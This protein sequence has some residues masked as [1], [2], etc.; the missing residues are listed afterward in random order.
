MKS[1]KK[2]KKKGKL[3]VFSS[4]RT[5]SSTPSS[6]KM[7]LTSLITSSITDLYNL[8]MVF[9][10]AEFAISTDNTNKKGGA[11]RGNKMKTKRKRGK[12]KRTL[13]GDPSHR[14]TEGKIFQT[15]S[16]PDGGEGSGERRKGRTEGGGV[17]PELKKKLEN[18]P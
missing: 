3:T 9:V 10:F 11:P 17:L 7:S 6:K 13:E 4:I 14:K 2:E 18:H 12:K 5:C 1:V 15:K 8:G 16:D